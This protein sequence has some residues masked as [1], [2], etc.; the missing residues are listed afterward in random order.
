[1]QSTHCFHCCELL[2]AWQPA[3]ARHLNS[4]LT[5]VAWHSMY[6]FQIVGVTALRTR[7]AGHATGIC[8]GQLQPS[9]RLSRS[10]LHCTQMQPPCHAPQHTCRCL[11]TC[12]S[13]DGAGLCR[14]YSTNVIAC[15][16]WSCPELL[17]SSAWQLRTHA[18]HRCQQAKICPSIC[19]GSARAR[20][21]PNTGDGRH[22]CPSSATYCSS[23]AYSRPRCAAIASRRFACMPNLSR[24]SQP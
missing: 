7:Q 15:T 17:C 10:A 12:I 8:W 2:Q 3:S 4:M 24:Q 11:S 13:R 14:A 23:S 5:F 19:G 6:H 22:S 1:M 21:T 9:H 16:T 18:L 20:F